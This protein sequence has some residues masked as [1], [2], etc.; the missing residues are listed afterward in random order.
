MKELKRSV[1]DTTGG[2][3]TSPTLLGQLEYYPSP[4]NESER[5]SV[6]ECLSYFL[7][8]NDSLR[9]KYLEERK[10]LWKQLTADICGSDGDG[11]G[12]GDEE[13]RQ[14][15]IPLAVSIS[16]GNIPLTTNDA[17]KVLP[18]EEVT[19]TFAYTSGNNYVSPAPRHEIMLNMM[20]SAASQA[21]QQGTSGSI[22]LRNNPSFTVGNPCQ[23]YTRCLAWSHQLTPCP[24]SDQAAVKIQHPEDASEVVEVQK[25]KTVKKKI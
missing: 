11:D 22:P 2:F 4:S 7:L 19:T 24:Q 8:P 3:H 20:Q 21:Y 16:S 17:A 23:P 25:K 13:S 14:R 9:I 12:D 15:Q 6:G 1:C 5:I 18:P 10:K